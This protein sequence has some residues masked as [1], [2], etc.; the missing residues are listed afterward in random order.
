MT[1]SE[2]IK[3]VRGEDRVTLPSRHERLLLEFTLDT[4]GEMLGQFLLTGLGNKKEVRQRWN[5]IINFTGD[6][7]IAQKRRLRVI[8]YELLT[9]ESF[10]PGGRDPLV[11]L[12]LLQILLRDDQASNTTL[13]YRDEEVLNLLGWENST[14]TRSEISEALDRYA[15]LMYQW[16]MN[17]AELARRDLTRYKVNE[18]MISGTEVTNQEA[19]A[20]GQVI[21]VT[22]RMIFNEFFIDGLLR[23]S[24]F[25]IAWDQ[26][27][28]IKLVRPPT[29]IR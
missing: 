6:D 24:L 1:D 13:L 7:G 10:L 29:G 17:S 25:E 26:V 12:A 28:S 27:R 18:R 4:F 23:R 15:L 8:T 2:F 5:F 3:L 16:E 11:L 19:G 21:H 22:N 14:E 9:G 20:V